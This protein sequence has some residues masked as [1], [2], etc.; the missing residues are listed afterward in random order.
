MTDDEPKKEKGG[1]RGD[2]PA[3]STPPPE[4]PSPKEPHP[5]KGAGRRGGVQQKPG[6][7][8]GETDP[9][10]KSPTQ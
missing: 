10:R 2:Q 1:G 7:Q 4:H 6:K 5:S 8:R 3:E 9:K